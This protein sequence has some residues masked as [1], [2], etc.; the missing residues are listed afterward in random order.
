MTL[1]G[2]S[3]CRDVDPVHM[4]DLWLSARS[5][6]VAR[7][8]STSYGRLVL[9]LLALPNSLPESVPVTITMNENLRS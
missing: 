5:R 6:I 9:L 4:L 2:V 1:V 3:Q 7:P 8:E